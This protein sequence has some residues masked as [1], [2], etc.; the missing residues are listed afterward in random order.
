MYLY[1]NGGCNYRNLNSSIV[2]PNVHPP[3]PIHDIVAACQTLELLRSEYN[4]SDLKLAIGSLLI[5]AKR[6]A[7]S[8]EWSTE[9]VKTYHFS[10]TGLIRFWK[11]TEHTLFK[12]P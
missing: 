8:Y 2:V 6:F 10:F 12:E 9:D 7:Q 4:S 1:N 11:N 5:L 3:K